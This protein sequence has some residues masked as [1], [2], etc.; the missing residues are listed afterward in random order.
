M[1]VPRERGS[2]ILFFILIALPLF[3]ACFL[4]AQEAEQPLQ[5][6]MKA[7]LVTLDA[8]QQELLTPTEQILPGQT[9]E[10]A[11]DYSNVSERD[12]TE[13]SIIGPIPEGTFYL[14]GS[15]ARG[16]NGLPQFSVDDA[17]SFHYEPVKYKIKQEDGSEIE[18]TAT[19]DLYTQIRWRINSLQ[20][21]EKL[22]LKYR[23]QVK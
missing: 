3:C 18:K 23:V 16:K 20:A 17:K 8:E 11:L 21:G 9:I 5:S 2:R 7:F 15:A 6:S 4:S 10:Y 1:N 12:L 22:T 19:P 13:V 14:A